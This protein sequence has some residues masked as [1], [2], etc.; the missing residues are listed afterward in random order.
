[1]IQNS[2]ECREKTQ[3]KGETD[4]SEDISDLPELQGED[5]QNT[6]RKEKI[7]NKSSKNGY[8]TKR[9]KRNIR[10]RIIEIEY[11]KARVKLKKHYV[12][13][14]Q[15]YLKW[16]RI[17]LDKLNAKMSYR[18]VTNDKNNEMAIS[19]GKLVIRR[20]ETE[21]V[22]NSS[23]SERGVRTKDT[24]HDATRERT[25][26]TTRRLATVSRQPLYVI[27]QVTRDKSKGAKAIMEARTRELIELYKK[28]CEKRESQKRYYD[29]IE[30]LEKLIAAI[31]EAD[32][33]EIERDRQLEREINEIQR[34]YNLR[35]DADRLFRF[36]EN[37]FTG[38]EYTATINSSVG[39][40]TIP[41]LWDIDKDAMLI[42][43]LVKG[44]EARVQVR[45]MGDV[46]VDSIFE[47]R[48]EM[49]RRAKPSD[50]AQ[51]AASEATMREK[52]AEKRKIS[53]KILEIKDVNLSEYVKARREEAVPS[54]SGMQ[55]K[56]TLTPREGSRTSMETQFPDDGSDE[57]AEA[58]K[59]TKRYSSPGHNWKFTTFAVSSR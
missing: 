9:N 18:V 20:G 12:S 5:D 45:R 4:T 31:P 27:G 48:V 37:I 55:R 1:M 14:L 38:D 16:I 22:D 59:T 36:T 26:L 47:M 42:S 58:P 53:P 19:Y 10:K 32:E 51:A 49:P 21:T 24:T 52:V 35:N 30:H 56:K 33:I 29:R 11:C 17:E 50:A 39:I 23:Q 28:K 34:E 3:E 2:E 43:Y 46:D 7:I 25:T 13:Y 6:C 15:K 40:H 41:R 54:T 57:D 44:K 8:V